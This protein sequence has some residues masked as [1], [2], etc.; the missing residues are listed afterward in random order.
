[1]QIVGE[2]FF[3][4]TRVD[5]KISEKKELEELMESQYSFKYIEHKV[6]E[7]QIFDFQEETK[8]DEYFLKFFEQLRKSPAI[9]NFSLKTALI[10]ASGE[11]TDFRGKEYQLLFLI[12]EHLIDR[13]NAQF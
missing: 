4:K 7:V 8:K 5:S 1:L 12:H 2:D 6:R 10:D 3:E 11:L 13:K 9:K